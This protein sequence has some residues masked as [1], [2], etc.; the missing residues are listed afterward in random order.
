LQEQ[1]GRAPVLTRATGVD[2]SPTRELGVATTTA[3]CA[4]PNMSVSRSPSSPC[5][6]SM[7]R[8]E[9]TTINEGT[10]TSNEPTTSNHPVDLV[11]GEQAVVDLEEEN[12]PSP[13]AMAASPYSDTMAA[14][15]RHPGCLYSAKYEGSTPNDVRLLH[16][17]HCDWV[18]PLSEIL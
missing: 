3:R 15:R 16:C 14:R 2:G 1:L 11:P 12:V 5:T 4:Q 6:R 13:E 8:N 17:T 9:P 7:T 18:K 10:T